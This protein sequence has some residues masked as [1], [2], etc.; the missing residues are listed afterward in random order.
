MSSDFMLQAPVQ[1]T[2]F[3]ENRIIFSSNPSQ[4]PEEAIT[5]LLKA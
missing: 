2:T 4:A 1:T 3:P 5:V